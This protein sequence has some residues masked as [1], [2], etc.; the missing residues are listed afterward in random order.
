MGDLRTPFEVTITY[1]GARDHPRCWVVSPSIP[2]EKRR[3][4]WGDCSICPFLASDD[5]WVWDRDT[6]ADYV[7]HISVWLVTWLV[8][9]RTGEWI[10]GEHSGTPQY[11]LA[12][13]KPNDQCWCRSGRRYR[14]CHM[15]EDQIEA[16]RQGFRGLL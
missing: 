16:A 14:K 10:V 5:T 6:V 7:A 11:H 2:P 8:F 1:S 12:V 9:D 15:R 13:V 4:M 3:H